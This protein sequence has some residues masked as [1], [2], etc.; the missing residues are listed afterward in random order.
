MAEYYPRAILPVQEY[1]LCP[2]HLCTVLI[3]PFIKSFIDCACSV[4][5]AEYYPRFFLFFL[6]CM[7]CLCNYIYKWLDVQVFSDED[8]KSKVPSPASSVLHA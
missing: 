2:E 8:Y 3:I 6:I 4:K 5:M 1:A 7:C